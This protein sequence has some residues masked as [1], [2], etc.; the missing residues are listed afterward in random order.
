VC[1]DAKCPVRACSNL[2]SLLTGDP[3]HPESTPGG[4]VG[5]PV[6]RSE[7]LVRSGS[8][9]AVSK[10]TGQAIVDPNASESRLNQP[11][12]AGL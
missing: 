4:P 7:C 9:V 2:E 10:T 8:S 1:T 6:Q 12:V 5:G 11:A 3:D